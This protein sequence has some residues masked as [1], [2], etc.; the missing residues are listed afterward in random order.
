[1]YEIIFIIVGIYYC[2][3]LFLIFLILCS[4]DYYEGMKLGRFLLEFIPLFHIFKFFIKL[5][6]ISIIC[7]I[8]LNLIIFTKFFKKKLLTFNFKK[9]IISKGKQL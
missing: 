3:Q 4:C 1:M 9:I 8:L 5:D 6:Y 7:K 2:L